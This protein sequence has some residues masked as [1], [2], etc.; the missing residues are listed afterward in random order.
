MTHF[1]LLDNSLEHRKA[2]FVIRKDIKASCNN[3]AFTSNFNNDK[4]ALAQR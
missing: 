2:Q 3:L 1:R 4:N